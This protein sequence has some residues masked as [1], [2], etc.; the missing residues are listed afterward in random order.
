MFGDINNSESYVARGGLY[1]VWI[2]AREGQHPPL[3]SIWIDPTMKAFEPRADENS[4]LLPVAPIVAAWG[5]REAGEQDE[6]QERERVTS[7]KRRFSLM[8][9]SLTPV[10]LYL[11]LLPA[12]WSQTTGKITGIVKD[13]TDAVVAG[14]EVAALSTTVSGAASPCRRAAMLGVSP[15][16]NCSWRLPSPTAPTTTRPVWIPTRTATRT[17]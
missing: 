17:P 4:S 7:V 11:I 1:R 13:Q 12:A 10:F 3:V 6:L 15:S 9:S 8:L 5:D 2:R 14:A 16:A